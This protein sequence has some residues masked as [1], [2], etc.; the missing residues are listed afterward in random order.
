M[1]GEIK[2]LRG[3]LEKTDAAL[4]GEIN[5]MRGDLERTGASLL[6]KMRELEQRMT[7]KLGG[8]LTLGFGIFFALDR[9]LA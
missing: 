9:L 8:M 5:A 7:I 4:R 3:D 6:G 2:A 1:R